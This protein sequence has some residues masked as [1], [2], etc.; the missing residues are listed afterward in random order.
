MIEG[1]LEISDSFHHGI[2]LLLEAV[3]APF[4]ALK[5]PLSRVYL[6]YL[7]GGILVALVAVSFSWAK[8]DGLRK[9]FSR[10]VWL[11]RSSLL[12]LRLMMVRALLSSL[13]FTPFLLESSESALWMHSQLKYRLGA[14]PLA[15]LGGAETE[16]TFFSLLVLA[17]ISFIA[18]DGARYLMHRL[19]H[20]SSW[21]WS[22]HQVHH[23]AEVLTPFTVYRSHPF[24]GLVMK[25][26]GALALG[27]S[28]GVAAWFFGYRLQVW[29]VMGV[30][31]LSALW[32]FFGANLR[33]SH[34]F[35]RYPAWLE[36]VFLSPAA[37]QLHHSRTNDES[38]ANFGAALSIWDRMGGTFR[39]P[40]ADDKVEFGLDEK[41]MNHSQKVH[42][43]I[44]GPFAEWALRI[45]K[46]LRPVD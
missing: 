20:R 44:F 31:G 34:I 40:Q 19:F 45:R 22:L 43:V 46:I 4:Y 7:L 25:T 11:H 27:V 29:Q 2:S 6:G 32:I 42:S 17:G 13:L 18:E 24:D 23:S 1:I 3:A 33:H 15:G 28:V 26:V 5:N 36:W 30:H 12:D 10:E 41:E 21:L 38:A 14:G 9:M 39:R 8:V 35:L 37:H 16:P